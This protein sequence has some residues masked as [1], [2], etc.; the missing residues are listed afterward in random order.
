AVEERGVT[1]HDELHGTREYFAPERWSGEGDAR[2]DLY[3]VGVMLHRALTGRAP[4]CSD[5]VP[6]ALP[7]EVAPAEVAS[8]CARLV[9]QRPEDRPASAMEA[10]RLLGVDAPPRADLELATPSMWNRE[11]PWAMDDLARCF[12]GSARLLH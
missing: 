10:L 12:H 11:S 8:L 3:A 6:L 5:G 4:S 7:P 2:S 1:A 9:A